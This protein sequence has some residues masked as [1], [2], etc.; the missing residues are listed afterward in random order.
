MRRAAGALAAALVL[1][2]FVLAWLQAPERVTAAH[3]LLVVAADPSVDKITRGL[4]RLHRTRP[5]LARRIDVTVRAPSNTLAEESLPEH[6]LLVVELLDRRWVAREAPRLET[7]GARRRVAIGP[8]GLGDDPE[9]PLRLGLDEDPVVDAYWEGSDPE[10]MAELFVYLAAR[11]L[12]IDGLE[13]QPPV[14]PAPDG[15]VVFDEGGRRLTQTW[16]LEDPPGPA[17]RVAILEFATRAR[18]GGLALSRA[19]AASLAE[20]GVEPVLVY[21]ERAVPAVRNRLLDEAGRPRVDAVVSFHFK[22]FEDGAAQALEELGVPVINAIRV[23]GRTVDEWQRSSQGLT[24]G[25]VA[26]QLA[27][28]EL[29]GLAPP[30][31][32]GAIDNRGGRVGSAPIAD[33]VERVAARAARL[34]RLRRL[35]PAERRVAILYWN[36]PPG[37]QNVGASYLNVLRSIPRML[38]TLEAEGYDVGGLDALEDEEIA[39]QIRTRGLNVGRFAPGELRRR[40]EGG[41]QVG[42]GLDTYRR[43]FKALPAPFREAVLAHWGPVEDA[44]IMATPLD[45]ALHLWLPILRFG[46]VVVLP[47]PDRA[48]TQD[49]EALYQSQDLPPHHQYVAAYLWLQHAFGA[50]VLIH[51]GTHGTHEWL[52]GKEAGLSGS[53]PGEV[54]VGDLHVV[55]PYIVDDVGEGIV[56]RRR[57]AATVVDHLTPALG[58]GGLAPELASLQEQ[59][60]GWRLARATEP[61][62]AKTLAREIEQA[63]EKEGLALDL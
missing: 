14:A 58:E 4:D 26:F 33:R 47:Q 59:L 34:A 30:N 12:G 45:G 51:T 55:Y 25:E 40:I 5:R 19:V 42:I 38:R 32:V 8:S 50:D 24:A 57:G 63:V 18:S 22:F 53:D 16:P 28:P 9:L 27:I 17:P 52:S 23:F 31:V 20:R 37:R 7:E 15:Y 10:S 2:A 48:R 35:P 61:D 46:N 39:E 56:A 60:R 41:E 54:L 49:L 3:R 1:G 13:V 44:E 6:D 29:A 62:R 21:G 11:H 43:W 36:Y